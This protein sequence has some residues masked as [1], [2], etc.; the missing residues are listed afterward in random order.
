MYLDFSIDTFI[1]E[2]ISISNQEN[3]ATVIICI[4]ED[5]FLNLLFDVQL[6][7]KFN[8]HSPENK[9]IEYKIFHNSLLTL[10]SFSFQIV[11]GK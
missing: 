10:F 4:L 9:L 3:I 11:A 8:F 2:Q 7:V 1:S 5:K 6:T